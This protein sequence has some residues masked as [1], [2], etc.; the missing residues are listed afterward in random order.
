MKIFGSKQNSAADS[1]CEA[2]SMIEPAYAKNFI[3]EFILG[4][5]NMQA[6]QRP[7]DFGG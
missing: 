5:P 2:R 3:C 4:K 6:A 7:L 1:T